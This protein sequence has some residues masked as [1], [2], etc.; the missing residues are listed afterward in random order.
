[1][2]PILITS[3]W[4]F[5]IFLYYF[6]WLEYIVQVQNCRIYSDL[7]VLAFHIHVSSLTNFD[8]EGE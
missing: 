1:M 5:Y 2:T 3:T 6:I 4:V 7:S 8:G